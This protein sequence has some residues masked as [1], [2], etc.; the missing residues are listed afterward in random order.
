MKPYFEEFGIS[1]PIELQPIFAAFN[2]SNV[3]ILLEIVPP[4]VSF[5]FGGPIQEV[6][7]A[8]KKKGSVIISRA[9]MVNE[10]RW[11]EEASADVLVVQ[12]F[13]AGGHLGYLRSNAYSDV[14]RMAL[15]FRKLLTH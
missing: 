1:A 11:L 14:G 7:A 4:V 5:H 6:V 8:L 12:G 10:A 3:H 9:T 13:E 2:G 15:I